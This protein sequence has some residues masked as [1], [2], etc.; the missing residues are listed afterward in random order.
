MEKIRENVVQMSRVGGNV[1]EMKVKGDN[2]IRAEAARFQ[3]NRWCEYNKTE[4]G[5]VVRGECGRS[6]TAADTESEWEGK[7]R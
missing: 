3:I 2:C 5:E 7:S 4:S 1:L 6:T